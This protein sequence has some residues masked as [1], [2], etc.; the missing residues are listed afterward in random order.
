MYYLN[1]ELIK[2]VPKGFTT[3]DEGNIIPEELRGMGDRF[4]QQQLKATGKAPGDKKEHKQPRLVKADVLADLP[5]I[6]GLKKLTMEDLQKLVKSDCLSSGTKLTM[7]E[8]RL[9]APYVA[10][11]AQLHPDVD[12][13]KLTV[14]ELKE[15]ISH[16]VK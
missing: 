10:Q 3:D 11:A 1:G 6:S 13:A 16:Y 2:E 9:K 14:A 7:P 12:W 4:Y 5:E 8:G 15:L